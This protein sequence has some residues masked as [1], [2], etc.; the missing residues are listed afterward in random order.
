MIGHVLIAILFVLLSAVAVDLFFYRLVRRFLWAFL[1]STVVLLIVWFAALTL[2]VGLNGA[3]S[4]FGLKLSVLLLPYAACLSLTIGIVVHPLR[5]W[6]RPKADD[7]PRCEK[8]QYDLT[9]NVSGIC[10]ECGTRI[11]CEER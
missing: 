9:G 5:G 1:L 3:I 7:H 10:P 6:P 8:C 2:A 11:C 4:I